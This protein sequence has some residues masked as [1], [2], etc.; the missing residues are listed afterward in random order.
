MR[1]DT[2]HFAYDYVVRIPSN[3]NED[4]ESERECDSQIA[5]FA[6]DVEM[7][8]LTGQESGRPRSPTAEPRRWTFTLPQINF[9]RVT[10][11]CM[12]QTAGLVLAPMVLLICV[13]L[14]MYYILALGLAISSIISGS[15]ATWR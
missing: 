2:P 1:D 12:R 8:D 3:L 15:S 10:E 13:L 4:R 9:P 11:D 14:L 7:H 6:E 5:Q